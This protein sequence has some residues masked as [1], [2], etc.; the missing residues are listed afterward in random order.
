MVGCQ[1]KTPDGEE[2]R[3]S[4]MHKTNHRNP[5]PNQTFGFIVRFCVG[6]AN[7]AVARGLVS[8]EERQRGSAGYSAAVPNN[9]PAYPIHRLG[10][11]SLGFPEVYRDARLL[12]LSAS[13]QNQ[14]PEQTVSA[15]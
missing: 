6:N 4:L 15:H 5:R 13:Q 7:P 1:A 9:L 2:K 8:N 14:Y 11:I 10:T 12:G 3:G